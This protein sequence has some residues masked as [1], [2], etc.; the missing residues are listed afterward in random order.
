MHTLSWDE[1]DYGNNSQL[2]GREKNVYKKGIIAI[3]YFIRVAMKNKISSLE[4]S[5]FLIME[6]K[7]FFME[8]FDRGYGIFI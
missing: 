2:R 3:T 7:A 8:F 5:W 4:A 1:R 6:L